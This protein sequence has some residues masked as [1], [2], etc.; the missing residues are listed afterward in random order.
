MLNSACT[1]SLLGARVGPVSTCQRPEARGQRLLF[2][3]Y[4]PVV[5]LRGPGVLGSFVVLW[6]KKRVSWLFL[7]GLPWADDGVMLRPWSDEDRKQVM[8][9][10]KMHKRTK[11]FK[12]FAP[13]SVESE[14][15]RMDQNTYPGTLWGGRKSVQT[16]GSSFW[17][18]WSSLVPSH[19]AAGM[20]PGRDECQWTFNEVL[21]NCFVTGTLFGEPS[22]GPLETKAGIQARGTWDRSQVPLLFKASLFTRLLPLLGGPWSKQKE[23]LRPALRE[24]WTALGLGANKELNKCPLKSC[25]LL[26]YV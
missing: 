6:C 13:S 16:Q 21:I 26:A 25:I 23:T 4:F 15:P 1:F 8:L 14:S 2:P 24:L 9:R 20:P 19:W 7:K 10:V 18:V 22:H 17:L 3:P 12:E 5:F 11:P